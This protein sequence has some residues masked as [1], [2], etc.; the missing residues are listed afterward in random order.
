MPNIFDAAKYILE[1]R[2][3]VSTLK[4]HFLLYL[5][6]GWSL[7]WDEAELFPEDFEA[8]ANGPVYPELYELHKG[9]VKMEMGDIPGD[10]LTQDALRGEQIDTLDAVLRDYGSSSQSILQDI[11]KGSMPYRYARDGYGP[12][13]LCNEIIKKGDMLWYFSALDQA[14][15]A[16]V[17]VSVSTSAVILQ[18]LESD[19]AW[20]IGID[21]I[22]SF[23]KYAFDSLQEYRLLDGYVMCFHVNTED[24]VRTAAYRP[25]VFSFDPYANEMHVKDEYRSA[26]ALRHLVPASQ[27]DERIT[28]YIRSF[29]RGNPDGAEDQ[30][31]LLV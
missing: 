19:G 6:Q 7:T 30:D 22:N 2:G 25:E 26:K 29:V 18:L 17:P 13:M 4:L 1:D 14:P 23:L 5:A 15:M 3:E 20:D 9:K 21:R 11:V 10:L 27:R 12:G 31:G 8:W 24:L 28:R 16:S